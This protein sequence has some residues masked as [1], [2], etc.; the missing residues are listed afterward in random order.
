MAAAPYPSIKRQPSKV[1]VE[2]MTTQEVGIQRE[3]ILVP[4]FTSSQ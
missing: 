2:N 3:V 4:I 1:L